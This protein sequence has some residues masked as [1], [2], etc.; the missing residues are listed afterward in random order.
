MKEVIKNNYKKIIFLTILLLICIVV[1]FIFKNNTHHSPKLVV[2]NSSVGFIENENSKRYKYLIGPYSFAL[3]SCQF[4]ES[5]LIVKDG[6]GNKIETMFTDAKGNELENIE[7][8]EDFYLGLEQI[9][10]NTSYILDVTTK[11]KRDDGENEDVSLEL[12][13]KF[14]SEITIG[15]IDLIT[16]DINGNIES[17]KTVILYDE[18]LNELGRSVSGNDGKINYYKVPTGNYKLVKI[19]ENGNEINSKEVKVNGGKT[20]EVS[21]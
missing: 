15:E 19:D 11:V 16:Y 14:D 9:P 20:T 3:E 7:E 4:I 13:I 17:G 10:T 12:K 5:N 8:K 21:L 6:N 18:A 2:D 1:I